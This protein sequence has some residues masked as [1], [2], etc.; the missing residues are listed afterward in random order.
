MPEKPNGEWTHLRVF[1]LRDQAQ[2]DAFATLMDEAGKRLYPD[3]TK[4]P[5]SDELRDLVKRETWRAF[6]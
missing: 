6:Q 4:K 1:R 2:F 5:K 3:P